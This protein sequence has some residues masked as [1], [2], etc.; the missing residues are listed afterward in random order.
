MSRV[1]THTS[2]SRY[3]RANVRRTSVSLAE[4]RRIAL[5]AQ[6]LATPRPVAAQPRSVARVFD[7]VQ[8]VQMDSVNV[9]VRAHE[10]PLWTRL[11]AHGRD[12]LPR[13]VGKRE[14]FE[15]WAHEA[16]LCPVALQPLLRWRMAEAREGR[17]TWA[18]VAGIARDRPAFV[19]EVHDEIRRRGPLAA[20]EVTAGGSAPRR[21]GWWE[22]SDHKR[23]LEYLFWAGELTATRREGS[24]ERVYDLPER[25]LPPEILATPTPAVADAQR[26]LLHRAAGALGIATVGDLA[27]YFR[28]RPPQARPLV[29]E[30]VETGALHEVAVEGWREPGYL[31][32]EATLPRRIDAATLVSP[33]DSLVW[34]RPRTERLFGFHYRLEIYTPAPKR[35]FG[36]YVLPFLLGDRLV[37]RV[38]LKADRAAKVL[39]VPGSFAEAG[40]DR[41]ALAPVL[42]R[43][44]ALMA[45]WLGLERVAIGA[46]GDLAR[47]LR[48]A[49][50]GR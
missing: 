33:F 7:R 9:L 12:A 38:D 28:I 22:W 27:D 43:E 11:G 17:G 15:Y 34:C 23:A 3:I 6:G 26:A 32:P 42:A 14:L 18:H 41:H 5:A 25:V 40:V 35:R 8:L 31:D 20:G 29:R 16:S 30:L 44:L 19:N 36:Y 49:V 46:R 50:A 21:S 2:G 13:A 10:L 24:F 37:A 45:R 1:D 48:G 39:L 4:A 47:E